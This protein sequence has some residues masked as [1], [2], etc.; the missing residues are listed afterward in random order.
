MLETKYTIGIAKKEDA[1]V[2]ASFMSTMAKETENL[3]L[4]TKLVTEAVEYLI[5]SDYGETL[6]VKVDG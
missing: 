6:V 2:M 4:N 3:T 1:S 5:E